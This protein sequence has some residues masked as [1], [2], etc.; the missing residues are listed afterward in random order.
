ML[1][2]GISHILINFH[3]VTVTLAPLLMLYPVSSLLLEMWILNYFVIHS[4]IMMNFY[5]LLYLCCWSLL[6]T[7]CWNA[8][9]SNHPLVKN[10]C[11]NYIIWEVTRW[12]IWYNSSFAFQSSACQSRQCCP[13]CSWRWVCHSSNCSFNFQF[14]FF[15]FF[16][17]LEFI[18]QPF[19]RFKVISYFV[20]PGF[21][22]VNWSRF[23]SHAFLQYAPLS[24]FIL[25][26]ISLISLSWHQPQWWHFSS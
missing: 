17:M 1:W 7:C 2:N 19:N 18:I 26:S 24:F 22:I 20:I 9:Y 15:Y 12:R 11:E 13:W 4:K 3:C 6:K 14:R 16:Y 5:W 10:L 25:F 8:E 21:F 23:S